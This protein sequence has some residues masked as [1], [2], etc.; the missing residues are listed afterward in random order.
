MKKLIFVLFVILT[1]SSCRS[2]Y[3]RHGLKDISVE[4]KRLLEA[5]SSFNIADTE[6]VADILSS[7]NSKLDSLNKYGV[8]NSSLP[9]M[10]KFSQI[11]KP[12][13]DYLNNFSSI[14]KEYAYSFDQLDD[15]EYDLKAKNVSKE[16]FSIYMDSEKSANDR[17]ILKSNLISN[18]AAREIESYKN[19]FKDR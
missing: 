15:L 4:R 19:L 3:V 5:K 6:Q 13:L 11:K 12:L 10:T 17:L 16:A 9:L 7:Y 18:S 1:L 8:D 14:K 2:G